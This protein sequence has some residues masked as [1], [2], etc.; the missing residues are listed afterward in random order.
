MADSLFLP[1]ALFDPIRKTHAAAFTLFLLTIVLGTVGCSNSAVLV[2]APDGSPDSYGPVSAEQLEG[3][4]CSYLPAHHEF[5][6]EWSFKSDT[7]LIEGQNIAPDIIAG[8][9]GPNASA[10]RIEG[11]WSIDRGQ[12]EFVVNIGDQDARTSKFRIYST[13]VIRIETPKRQYVF[14]Q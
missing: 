2:G 12:I 5:E 9:L 4:T 11:T 14:S 7:F 3:T 10:N 8:L 1:T 13:G 6:F